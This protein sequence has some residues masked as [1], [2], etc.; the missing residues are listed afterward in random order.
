MSAFSCELSLSLNWSGLII[1]LIA[2]LVIQCVTKTLTTPQNTNI[3]NY[4]RTLTEAGANIMVSYLRKTSMDSGLDERKTQTQLNE[5]IDKITIRG[6]DR[7]LAIKRTA[8]LTG[9]LISG[10]LKRVLDFRLRMMKIKNKRNSSL[11]LHFR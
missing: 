3:R 9:L 6:K 7:E 5:L 4:K 11:T 2:K 8:V 10:V 1:I